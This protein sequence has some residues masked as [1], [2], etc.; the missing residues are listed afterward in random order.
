[1]SM[2]D[3][4]GTGQATADQFTGTDTQDTGA[5]V[6]VGQ[7][8]ADTQQQQSGSLANPFLAAVDETDRETVA[9]YIDKWDA[10]VQRRFAE[11]DQALRPYRELGDPETL[12]QA[13][14]IFNLLQNSPEVL[15]QAL[16]EQF[17]QQQQ[18]ISPSSQGP[19]NQP[20]NQN[21]QFQGLPD[22]LSPLAPVFDQFGQRL[23]QYEHRFNQLG[24]TLDAVS[25]FLVT[26][27][28]QTQQAQ[29]DQQIEQY[30]GL[31]KTEF[32]EFD[33]EYVISKMLAGMDGAEA[34][35]QFKA[36]VQQQVNANS[37]QPNVPTVLSGGGGAPQTQRRPEELS[38]AETRD[39]VASVLTQ[40]RG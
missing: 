17:G 32:G 20:G 13:M 14:Q 1:M 23:N 4:Q 5:P 12:S 33:E 22:E 9:K 10:N 34:V 19:L 40:M 31:L 3:T 38:Q 28:Q 8:P 2:M 27:H 24:Q 30:F 35:Q 36:L 29:E 11:K 7:N 37:T 26:Q 15:Y 25:K 16:S 21:L 18:G 39:L 6:G